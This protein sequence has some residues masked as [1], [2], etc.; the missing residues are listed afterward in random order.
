MFYN[1]CAG[2]SALLESLKVSTN[3][4]AYHNVRS[5]ENDMDLN[6]VAWVCVATLK[7]SD[8]F[9]RIYNLRTL[10]YL[11]FVKFLVGSPFLSLISSSSSIEESTLQPCILSMKGVGF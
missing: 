1:S 8:G 6:F 3:L 2:S 5:F 11:S 7:I 4:L 9:I 10:L